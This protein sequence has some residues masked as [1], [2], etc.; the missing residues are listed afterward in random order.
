[1]APRRKALNRSW[2][3]ARAAT[4]LAGRRFANPPWPCYKRFD[5]A[6]QG[7]ARI[8]RSKSAASTGLTTNETAFTEDISHLENHDRAGARHPAGLSQ[9]RVG[10]GGQAAFSFISQPDQ[11]DHRAADLFHA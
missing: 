9:A 1:M 10:R 7:T 8:L 5:F 4:P 3:Q 2:A 11:G 6:K